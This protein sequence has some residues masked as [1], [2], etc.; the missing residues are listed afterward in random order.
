LNRTLLTFFR[1][2][3]RAIPKLVEAVQVSNNNPILF[4]FFT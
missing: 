3:G 4:F 2:A 1:I